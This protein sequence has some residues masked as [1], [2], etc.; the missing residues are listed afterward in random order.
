VVIIGPRL[1]GY[2]ALTSGFPEPLNRP[3]QKKPTPDKP[4][5]KK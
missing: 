5:P 1:K 3:S 2:R 4:T